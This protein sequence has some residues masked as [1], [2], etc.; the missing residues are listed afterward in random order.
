MSARTSRYN[1]VDLMICEIG[2]GGE[3][4]VEQEIGGDI[5]STPQECRHAP[6]IIPADHTRM[7][8]VFHPCNHRCPAFYEVA[9]TVTLKCFPGCPAFVV[10]YDFRPAGRK[11]KN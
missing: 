2:F 6:P 11:E 4:F 8:S 9:H 1:G 10:K 5:I 7:E 3:L